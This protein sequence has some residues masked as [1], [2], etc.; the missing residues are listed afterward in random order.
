VSIH[1]IN[2]LL[3]MYNIS[4]YLNIEFNKQYY[5]G[6][7]GIIGMSLK[8]FLVFD[9]WLGVCHFINAFN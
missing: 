8:M 3:S 5:S 6:S 1:T 7:I 4:I 2:M 9:L